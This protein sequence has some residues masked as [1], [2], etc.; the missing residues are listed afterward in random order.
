VT[1]R[2]IT[3]ALSLA[4]LS[5]A[6][7]S[8]A[9]CGA[10]APASHIASSGSHPGIQIPGL[11]GPAGPATPAGPAD[12]SLAGL[13]A[14]SLVPAATVAQVLGQLARSCYGPQNGAGT[15]AFYDLSVP[16]SPNNTEAT[17]SVTIVERSGFDAS[18]SFAQG[19]GESGAA[20]VQSVPALGDAAFS[21]TDGGGPDYQLWA[22]KGGRALEVDIDSTAAPDEQRA[23]QFMTDALSSL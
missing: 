18:Q 21:I 3:A 5:L 19:V 16:G 2:P 8:L 14:C 15:L 10:A 22:A 17:L 23:R 7:I 20:K 6:G 1:Y 11:G 9:G 12:A 4:A 13:H